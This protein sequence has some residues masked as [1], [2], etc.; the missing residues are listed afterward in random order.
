MMSFSLNR[1]ETLMTGEERYVQTDDIDKPLSP[2][3][4]PRER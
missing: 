4:L 1:N 3:P 2:S